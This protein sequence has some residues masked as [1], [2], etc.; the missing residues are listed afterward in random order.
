MTVTL[1]CQG[2]GVAHRFPDSAAAEQV[3]CSACGRLIRSQGPAPSPT[4][5]LAAREAAA[6]L[7]RGVF[8]EREV[9]LK[10]RPISVLVA[11]VAGALTVF[12]ELLAKLAIGGIPGNP[13]LFPFR[14]WF[15]FLIV[16][17]GLFFGGRR[18]WRV[19]RIGAIVAAYLITN[20][21][22]NFQVGKWQADSSP[23]EL[24]WGMLR[25]VLQSV[26]LLIVF[27][28]LGTRSAREYFRMVCPDCGSA[29]TVLC[30]FTLS[31]ARCRNC[32]REW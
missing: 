28:A 31:R 24:A 13:W 10:A 7:P 1:V 3:W 2:C 30:G 21:T 20:S 5:V 8:R 11:L 15:I 18:S 27:L 22:L 23:A 9:P 17:L 4:A 19:T 14:S 16:W 29:V 26:P 32:E 6:P 25:L 12:M